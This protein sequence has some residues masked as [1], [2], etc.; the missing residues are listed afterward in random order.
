[1]KKHLLPLLTLLLFVAC[2]PQ[3]TKK[4]IL[5]VSILPQ[6]Y[7]VEKIAG[8]Y[9]EV[10]VMIKPGA[11]PAT[12][13]P[14]PQQMSQL[15]NAVA[16]LRI[17]HIGFEQTWIVRIKEANPNLKVTDT[18]KGIQLIY[19]KEE[20]H[21]DHVHLRGIDPHVWMSPSTLREVAQNTF[22]LL[23][24][25]APDQKNLFTRNYEQLEKEID[26]V[27]QLAKA[28][29]SG[30]TGRKFMIFHPALG[31]L[32]RDYS[33]EQLSLEHDGKEP[34]A[35]HLRHIIDE[36]NTENIRIIFIQKEFNTEQAETVAREIN[37][38]I[39]QINPLEY[40][41]PEQMKEIIIK[42]AEALN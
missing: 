14:S 24:S 34:S 13:A 17:G 6:K 40:N 29:L 42:L 7:L 15:E 27:Q 23:L 2:N 32:A 35:Q 1:M 16:Y 3:T 25:L 12:Y 19:A 36:A 11:S 22:K 18:S 21:G 39:I 9:F 28:K 37:G 10:N 5:T 38:Q 4:P 30:K 26:E 20:Q 8:N 41:W 33:L 31:Y